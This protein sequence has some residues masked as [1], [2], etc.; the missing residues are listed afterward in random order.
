MIMLDVCELDTGAG[1]VYCCGAGVIV[2][3]GLVLG[4][5]IIPFLLFPG[6]SFSFVFG[7][8]MKGMN[9]PLGYYLMDRVT[10]FMTSIL[11]ENKK[12]YVFVNDLF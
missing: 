7:V 1:L 6:D 8:S 10:S 9:L 4:C 5:A 12:T 2:V 11:I 3:M